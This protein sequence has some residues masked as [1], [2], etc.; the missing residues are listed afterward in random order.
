V[1]RWLPKDASIQLAAFS[2]F[3]DSKWITKAMPEAESLRNN[4]F[5]RLIIMLARNMMIQQHAT[6]Q[7]GRKSK[8]GFYE[9]PTKI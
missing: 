3:T 1:S 5:E 4:I 7:L 8:R 6:S 2:C 9:Y